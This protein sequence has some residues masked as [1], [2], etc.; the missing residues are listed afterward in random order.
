[1]SSDNILEAIRQETGEAL[2][3][4]VDIESEKDINGQTISQYAVV[5]D[6]ENRTLRSLLGDEKST[7]DTLK[8]FGIV[9]SAIPKNLEEQVTFSNFDKRII[10]AIEVYRSQDKLFSDEQ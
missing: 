3:T 8:N 10:S 1:M 2:G 6:R 4:K 5:K 9:N 7:L